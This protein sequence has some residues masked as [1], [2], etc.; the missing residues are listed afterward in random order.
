MKTALLFISLG[1]LNVLLLIRN[2]K[3]AGLKMMTGS[4]VVSIIIIII[5]FLMILAP[6]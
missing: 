3:R 4:L 1:L 5:G 2:S 6:K